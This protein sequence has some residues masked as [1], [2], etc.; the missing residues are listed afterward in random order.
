MP[1]V[2]TAW[3]T[4]MQ[5]W[6]SNHPEY[7]LE[8]AFVHDSSAC[9]ATTPKTETCRIEIFV[10]DSY[11]W[12]INPRD[13][14]LRA[15]QAQ[16]MVDIIAF[17][18]MGGYEADGVFFDEHESWSFNE[19][20]LGPFN[21]RIREYSGETNQVGAYVNDMAVLLQLEKAALGPNKTII[22][23]TNVLMREQDFQL[24]MAAGS[25]YMESANDPRR[26]GMQT[27]WEWI[28]RILSNGA[29]ASFN[30]YPNAADADFP[31][32]NFASGQDRMNMGW[33]A[34]FYMAIPSSP[35]NLAFELQSVRFNR[36]FES[37][38]YEAIGVNV[39]SPLGPRSIYREG[40]DPNGRNYR[41]WARDFDNAL[42]LSRPLAA[43]DYQT[44]DDTTGVTI[45]LPT[46]DAYL[47]LYSD[48]T[49]GSAANS[50]TLRNAEAAILLK[51]SR[52][53]DILDTTP[54]AA[55]TNL[56]VQ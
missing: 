49:R 52:L 36:P 6:Y 1:V 19:A 14:G 8:D 17:N 33:L 11:R 18:R 27:R 16:R 41:V 10:W 51:Q 26:D 38:W 35:D 13:P 44:Y 5:N 42:V 4:H 37:F 2:T 34:D 46:D 29:S 45:S 32:G 53:P 55:P 24:I 56:T 39:G 7:D 30:S 12:V 3:Y 31:R 23:N 50:I 15:Y 9:P 54:P 43:W 40:A 21:G 22:L 25:A 20:G 48:G 28:D 47:P